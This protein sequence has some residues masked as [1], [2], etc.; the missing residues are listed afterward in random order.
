MRFDT[1]FQFEEALAKYTGAPYVVVTDCCTH[2]IELCLRYDKVKECKLTPYTYLSIPMVLNQLGIDYE[3]LNHEWQRWAGE[4]P[5]VGTRIWDSARRLEPDM[6]REGQ[7]QCLSFGRTK[8]MELGRCGAVLLDDVEAYDIMSQQRSD[9][10]DLRVNPWIE[11]QV[12]I[13]GY[14][15]CPTLEICKQGIK[16]LATHAPQCQDAIYPD[17][18]EI[19]IKN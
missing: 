12:F 2:A 4:Y 17:C 1:L 5:L 8:P 15:Y 13:Q 6:Y 11:Q 3:F 7:M 14:H 9:G 19:L 10:R 16:K 18:R